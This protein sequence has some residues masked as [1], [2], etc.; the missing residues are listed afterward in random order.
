[1]LGDEQQNSS[2]MQNQQENFYRNFQLVNFSQ[3]AFIELSF[4]PIDQMPSGN[5]YSIFVPCYFD[6]VLFVQ[7]KLFRDCN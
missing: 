5:V 3:F 4:S 1:M 2:L 6:T 7:N